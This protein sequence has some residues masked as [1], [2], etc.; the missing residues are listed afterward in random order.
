[1]DGAALEAV[2]RRAWGTTVQVTGLSR[3][4]GGASRET[5]AFDATPG[6]GPDGGSAPVPLVLRRDRPDDADAAGMA[7]E[8]AAFT[9]AAAAGVPV[10]RLHAHGDGAVPASEDGGAPA[11]GGPAVGTPF[12]IVDR[13]DGETIPRR[14][15]R[16]E[17][18][19]AV[20]PRLARELGRVLARIHTI[21]PAD[22]LTPGVG[23]HLGTGDRLDALRDRHDRFGEPNPALELVF[24]WL[25]LHR[26]PVVEP[27]LVHGDFRTGNLLIGPGPDGTDGTDG[28]LGVLDWELVHAGDPMEDLGWLCGKAWRFGSPEPVGGFGPYDE[29]FDGYAEVAGTRPDPGVVR[30]WEVFAAVHWAVICRMQAERHLSGTERTVEM[31]VLGRRAAESEHDALLALGLTAPAAVPDLLDEPARAADLHGRPTVDELLEAVSGFLTDELPDALDDARLRF[32]AR[33]AANAL[34][35]ARREL[36]AGPAHDVAHRERLA[37]LGVTGDTALAAAIR[38]GG[39]DGR[40]DVVDAVRAD[41]VARLRVANPRHTGRPG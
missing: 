36:R 14:L 34:A 20:R 12:L 4:A 11:S 41:V 26:P 23:D 38:A 24:R 3:L 2:L 7:R 6:G 29:L 28:V 1:M 40:A 30:W 35:I 39:M 17:R 37:A 21:P 27:H 15:L 16:D 13:I 32:S 10:P 25:E 22:V 8:A 9:A 18:W 31:A 33:V 19:A 5:W